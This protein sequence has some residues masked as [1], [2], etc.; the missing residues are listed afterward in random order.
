MKNVNSI[1]LAICLS[2]AAGSVFAQD[3]G[4][5]PDSMGHDQTIPTAKAHNGMKKD[6]MGH[7]AM[8]MH[9]M[10]KGAKNSGMMKKDNADQK[11]MTNGSSQ[12]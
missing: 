5:V 8:K 11:A 7:D 4:K 3:V 1:A 10:S 9:S 2:L 12:H 6:A